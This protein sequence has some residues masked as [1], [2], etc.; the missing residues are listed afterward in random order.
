MV[1]PLWDYIAGHDHVTMRAVTIWQLAYCMQDVHTILHAR[2]PHYIAVLQ[3]VAI[4]KPVTGRASIYVQRL[5]KLQE[6]C[7][8]ALG[9]HTEKE[10]CQHPHS[11]D[12]VPVHTIRA[13][14]CSILPYTIYLYVEVIVLNCIALCRFAVSL[15]IDIRYTSLK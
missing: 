10:V 11:S 9:F 6:G 3:Y 8:V 5:L 12:P 15:H 4:I 1:A 2:C 13:I 7:I 14:R